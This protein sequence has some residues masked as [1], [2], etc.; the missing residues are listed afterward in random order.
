M[1]V[2]FIINDSIMIIEN[3]DKKF[4]TIKIF[5]KECLQI[6]EIQQTSYYQIEGDVVENHKFYTKKGVVKIEIVCCGRNKK[7]ILKRDS[8][9]FI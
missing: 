3:M 8:L 4:K 9:E 7:I 6:G 5:E 1:G 2:K